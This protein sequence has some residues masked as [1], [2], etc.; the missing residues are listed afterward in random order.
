MLRPAAILR[1]VRTVRAAGVCLAAVALWAAGAGC[2]AEELAPPFADWI[3][4]AAQPPAGRALIF[5]YRPSSSGSGIHP[6]LLVN[7]TPRGLLDART[8]YLLE[9]PPGTVTLTVDTV[10][11]NAMNETIAAGETKYVRVTLASDFASEAQVRLDALPTFAP[12][13]T[14]RSYPVS[15]SAEEAQPDL[16]RCR[17]VRFL[18]L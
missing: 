2:A 1:C 17:L 4:K 15:A 16:K 10:S 11:P 6:L 7:G 8:Y 13:R 3:A 18:R 9:V 14:F 12:L 5:V